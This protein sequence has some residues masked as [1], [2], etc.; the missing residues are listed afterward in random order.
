MRGVGTFHVT[1]ARTVTRVYGDDKPND[2]LLIDGVALNV[3]VAK[4]GLTGL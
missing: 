3:G 2:L 1:D 4:D